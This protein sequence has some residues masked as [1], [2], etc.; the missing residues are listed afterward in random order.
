M[1]D[2]LTNIF[3]LLLIFIISVPCLSQEARFTIPDKGETIL[4]R[5]DFSSAVEIDNFD[6]STGF[7]WTAIASVNVINRNDK[8]QIL[9]LKDELKNE[10]DKLKRVELERLLGK[11]E[12][13]LFWPKFY[14][15]DELY[16]GHIYDGGVN[17]KSEPQAMI[18]LLLKVDNR[19][20]DYFN[21]WFDKGPM[22]HYPGIS[23]S[24]LGRN[25]IIARCEIF[26][27]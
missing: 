9:L 7:Y 12:I 10:D 24:V 11:W 5:Q 14:V 3:I 15:K 25:M 27:P 20:N 2:Y 8:N 23:A 1:R 18:L 6:I 17:P 4:N 22:T 13:D 16:E 26:F 19:L 21:D